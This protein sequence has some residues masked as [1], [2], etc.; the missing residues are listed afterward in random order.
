MS[1]LAPGTRIGGYRILR[2][3]SDA[4]HFSLVYL[5]EP[6]RGEGAVALK[7]NFPAG[8]AYRARDG[9]TLRARDRDVF[10]WALERFER[11]A[12]FLRRHRH[13]GLVHVL[14]PPIRENGTSYMPLEYLTG[15]SLRRRIERRGAESEAQVR[16]W[17]DPVLAALESIEGVGTSHLDLSPDN[18][19][20]RGTGEPVLVDFGSARIGG[21]AP[22]RGT[23]MITNCGY[24][25]P[26]KL[27][28]TS[29]DIDA[30]ADVYSVA[31]LV[32]F[33]M[34]GREPSPAQDRLT[35]TPALPPKVAARRRGSPAFLA[36]IDKG[37][38]IAIAD[39]H[40]GA[41]AF[42]R[43]LAPGEHRASAGGS[44]ISAPAPI[45][46]PDEFRR[47]AGVAALV[48]FALLCLMS[49][50]LILV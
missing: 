2:T 10:A 35:G 21:V 33:A 11:E 7:E 45:A 22:T 47:R 34:T 20:F 31:A 29:R 18:I 15:G 36:A 16:T 27:S 37:F 9:A 32:N 23:R 30:R 43:A 4:G 26:E 19:L 39:R 6:P 25:A 40:R 50:T 8:A 1:S 42:R 17:L 44:D 3:L 46:D 28:R 14:G 48:A 5:A 41:A 13:P 24:S 49:I 38:A 12:E